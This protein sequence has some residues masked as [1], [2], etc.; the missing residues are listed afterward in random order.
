MISEKFKKEEVKEPWV[1]TAFMLHWLMCSD[2]LSAV[3]GDWRMLGRSGDTGLTVNE[4]FKLKQCYHRSDVS[5]VSETNFTDVQK[6]QGKV[7]CMTTTEKN[8]NGSGR[9]F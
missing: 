1:D 7:C 9:N 6:M 5:N 3:R 8:V 2:S 4:I